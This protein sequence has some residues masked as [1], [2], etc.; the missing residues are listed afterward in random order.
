MSSFLIPHV[1]WYGVIV[2]S[3]CSFRQN[4]PHSRSNIG[5]LLCVNQLRACFGGQ[6]WARVQA[7]FLSATLSKH[8]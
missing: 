2:K 3:K 5:R 6:T 8:I 4:L 1:S 7:L